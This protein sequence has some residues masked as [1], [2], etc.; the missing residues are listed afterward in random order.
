MNDTYYFSHDYNPRGDE[1]IQKLIFEMDW[2][3]YGLFWA[4]VELLYQNVGYMQYE[5]D[6]IA[7]EL[8]TQEDR[9]S[10]LINDF[11][12]FKIKDNCIYSDSVLHRLK[13]RK[14]KTITARKAAKIRWDKVKQNDANAMQMHSESNAIKESKVK[15]NKVNK[16]KVNNK[17][18]FQKEVFLFTQ[19]PK[20]MLEDFIR[21]W[22]EPNK[23]KTKMK[24]ELEKTWD[25]NLRLITW[26]KR[27]NNF[28]KNIKKEPIPII[29]TLEEGIARRQK[30]IIKF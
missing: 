1:K 2:Y 4:L 22:I 30:M 20:E 6:R 15:E 10:S 23:S 3:G 26:E 27:S 5:C 16:S 17:D 19:Y 8:R 9:I 25:T 12:L 24:W 28:N 13:K 18:I 21:H 29:E 14:G 11:G 7:F